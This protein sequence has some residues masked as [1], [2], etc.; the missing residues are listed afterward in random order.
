VSIA[1]GSLAE[2][3]TQM[4]LATRMNFLDE[5]TSAELW[6]RMQTTG[7]LINGLLRSLR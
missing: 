2:L 1:R 4:I 3:E 5:E 7:R 6:E